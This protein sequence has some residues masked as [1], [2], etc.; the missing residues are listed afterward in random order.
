MCYKVTRFVFPRL[1]PPQKR[2]VK[3][4][5]KNLLE[6]ASL[7]EDHVNFVVPYQLRKISIAVFTQEYQK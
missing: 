1:T 4:A 5:K 3:K 2:M 7:E 6:E